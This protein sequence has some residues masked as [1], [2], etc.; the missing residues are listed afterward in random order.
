VW[1]AACRECFEGR[2]MKVLFRTCVPLL[3]A[4]LVVGCQKSPPVQAAK[5][6][7]RAER[8]PQ[9]ADYL[10]DAVAAV[11][12]GIGLSRV[13]GGLARNPAVREYAEAFVE[14][15]TRLSEQLVDLLHRE[16]LRLPSTASESGVEGLYGLDA[17]YGRALDYKYVN[18][19]GGATQRALDDLRQARQ[20]SNDDEQRSVISDAIDA[21]ENEQQQIDVLRKTIVGRS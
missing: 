5:N 18:L 8:T 2:I 10:V 11:N 15:Q 13:A 9:E 14:F 19:I 7:T 17:V 6:G 1:N 3:I 4:F 12:R 21:M 20:A 16:G